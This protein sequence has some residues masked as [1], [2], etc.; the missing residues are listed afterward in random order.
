VLLI[1]GEPLNHGTD[2]RDGGDA[3]GTQA[4]HGVQE[5]VQDEFYNAS[6]VD[7]YYHDCSD[8]WKCSN[9]AC[10]KLETSEKRHKK[11]ASCAKVRYCSRPCQRGDW[12]AHK[13][14]CKILTECR[15]QK[16]TDGAAAAA[17]GEGGG[18]GQ[19]VSAAVL[20]ARVDKFKKSFMP[21][22]QLVCFFELKNGPTSSKRDNSGHDTFVVIEL[23]ALPD[24]CKAPRLQIATFYRQPIASLDPEIQESMVAMDATMPADS[25]GKDDHTAFV[26]I[27]CPSLRKQFGSLKPLWF[28]GDE[29]GDLSE[30]RLPLEVRQR[31]YHAEAVRYKDMINNMARGERQDLMAAA[32]KR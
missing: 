7:Q 11:C 4:I 15:Q 26:M 28:E 32:A 2:G 5:K 13:A 20:S 29:E 22:I 18:P 25:L 16:E 23:E 24:S 10:E 30:L 21:L 1:E 6:L 17:G 27:S 31:K 14:M 8:L 19:E 9:S 12:K 3:Q